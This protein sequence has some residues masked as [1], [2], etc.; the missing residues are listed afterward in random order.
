MYDLN[1]PPSPVQFKEAAETEAIRR[2]FALV[3]WSAKGWTASI[4]PTE[5]KNA[6]MSCN[7]FGLKGVAFALKSVIQSS[8]WRSVERTAL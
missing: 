4:L 2:P 6:P 3:R 5:G 7:A 8:W 1:L